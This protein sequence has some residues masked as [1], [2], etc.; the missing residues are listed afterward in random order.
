[1]RSQ[2][3]KSRPWGTQISFRQAPW[4]AGRP[5]NYRIDRRKM[6][7]K[8]GEWKSV[9][10]QQFLT[11]RRELLAR[12]DEALAHARS[13]AVATHHGVVGE[14]AVRDWLARFL[15]K[16]YGVI[17]GFIK[18]QDP[19]SKMTSHFDVIIYEQLEAPILWT[20]SNR[21]KSDQGLS[22]V[23]PAEYVRAIIEVKSAL[24]RKTMR[25]A[26][27]KLD[28]LRPLMMGAD[29]PREAYPKYL[30]ANTILLM[31]FFELRAADAMDSEV[32]NLVRDFETIRLFYGP[33]VLRGEGLHPDY[34]GKF[35]RLRSDEP[36]EPIWPET[37]MLGGYAHSGSK[38]YGPNHI[39]ANVMWGDVNFSGFAFDLLALLDGRFR[40]GFVSSFHG[41]DF[42]SV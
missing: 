1:M 17:S 25:D 20:E 2:V 33:V 9:A 14:A 5:P 28:Q 34:T 36:M 7:E 6:P 42:G 13:Q 11:A 15:P 12:Y 19:K 31:L 27:S 37:G 29:P 22:R 35:G 30:P 3:S 18:S 16:R 8:A 26:I 39:L 21:D 41:I 38:Q 32:L 24:S 23:I 4:N 10:W 40:P